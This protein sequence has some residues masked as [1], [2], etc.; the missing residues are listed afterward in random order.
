MTER[1]GASRSKTVTRESETIDP[2]AE[3]VVRMRHG[4]RVPPDMPLPSKADGLPEVM[5]KLREMELRALEKSGRLE[6]LAAEADAAEASERVK[7]KI[8]DALAEDD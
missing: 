6:A 7:E 3:R 4:L 8:V 1:K 5:Q 2:E